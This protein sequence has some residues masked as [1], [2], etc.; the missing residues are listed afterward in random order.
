[1]QVINN[2]VNEVQV[3]GTIGCTIGCAGGCML[4]NWTGTA[5]AV[6]VLAMS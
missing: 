3:G 4:T 2:N 6:A 1:M 5:I